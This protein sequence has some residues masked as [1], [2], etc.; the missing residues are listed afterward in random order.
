MASL[1]AIP[2]GIAVASGTVFWCEYVLSAPGLILSV[3][4]GGGTVTPVVSGLSN[5][6]DLTVADGAL[7]WS[8]SPP[9]SPGTGMI[10]SLSP[11]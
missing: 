7:Y 4:V 9:A 3:P 11:L 5:P 8:D 1:Q 6:F 2:L 10:F